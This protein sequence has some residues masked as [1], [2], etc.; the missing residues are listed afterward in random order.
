MGILE[1]N[2]LISWISFALS[3]TAGIILIIKIKGG[4]K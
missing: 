1:M 2:I 4:D 3:L